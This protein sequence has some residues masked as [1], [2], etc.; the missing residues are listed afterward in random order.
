[1]TSGAGTTTMQNEYIDRLRFSRTARSVLKTKLVTLRSKIP[2]CPILVFEGDDDKIVY[3]RWIPR[4]RP[5]LSYAAF[6]CKG[7]RAVASVQKIAAD[8]L[9][10]LRE[11]LY[12]FIDR[13]YDDAVDFHPSN[14]LFMTDRYSVENYLVSPDV[15]NGIARDEFP[16]HEYPDLV[17]SIVARF[18]QDYDVFLETTREINRRLFKYC[19]LKIDPPKSMPTKLALLA[20]VTIGDV[21]SPAIGIDITFPDI[22]GLA[23]GLNKQL[24]KDFD[25]LDPQFR[26]RGKN[27]LLFMG[28]WLDI[29]SIE[30]ERRSGVFDGLAL[31]GKVRKQEITL[32]AFASRSPMPRGLVEF[33][34]RIAA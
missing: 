15:V 32:G 14:E 17:E 10:S 13:D 16:C 5:N 3:G 7:K 34:D 24:C 18:E 11:G 6:V 28:K 20:S 27:A 25:E 23:V 33:V 12:L 21:R 4:I 1:M 26:Y 9:G 19:R 30:F 8:D 31:P 22:Y 2:S 29:L